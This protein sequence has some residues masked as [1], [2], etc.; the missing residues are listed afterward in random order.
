MTEKTAESRPLHGDYTYCLKVSTKTGE[1]T[2][3]HGLYAHEMGRCERIKS[4]DVDDTPGVKKYELYETHYDA[5]I[6]PLPLEVA[7]AESEHPPVRVLISR[8]GNVALVSS[9]L[10]YNETGFVAVPPPSE[11]SSV[12]STVD[13]VEMVDYATLPNHDLEA[14]HLRRFT[15]KGGD[16]SEDLSQQDADNIFRYM[17]AGLSEVD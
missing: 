16:P 14:A 11:Y 3:A 13:S 8:L 9:K 4:V 5:K 1:R 15:E 17:L 12:D 2:L 7:E 6:Q 10:G